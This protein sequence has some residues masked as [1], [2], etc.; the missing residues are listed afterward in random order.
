MKKHNTTTVT[1]LFF[2]IISANF[3]ALVPSFLQLLYNSLVE[4]FILPLKKDRHRRNDVIVTWK[5]V[6]H[7]S[8][9]SA[10][11][12]NRSRRVLD[13]ASMLDE[14]ISRSHIQPQQTSQQRRCG[15]AHYHAAEELYVAAFLD[16]CFWVL[17][18]VHVVHWHNNARNCRTF[19]QIICHYHTVT[20]PKT[21]AMTFPAD[22]VTLNFLRGLGGRT[23]VFSDHTVSF[24]LRI[25]VMD[26]CFILRYYPVEKKLWLGLQATNMVSGNINTILLLFVH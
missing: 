17:H 13:L 26:P 9:L 22:G 16:T 24:C 4:E 5:N 21:V 3:N 23:G 6:C 11:G 15:Q 7:S 25:K 12:T 19:C 20:V 18:V 10:V 2:H 14:V 8:V 1:S